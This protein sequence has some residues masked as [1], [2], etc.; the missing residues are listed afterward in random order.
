M[1]TCANREIRDL[2]KHIISL[3]LRSAAD[4]EPAIL[5][6]NSKAQQQGSKRQITYDSLIK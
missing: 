6:Q 1:L 5:A 3:Y 2:S 4:L